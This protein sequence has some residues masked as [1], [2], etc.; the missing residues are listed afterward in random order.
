MLAVGCQF[1]TTTGVDVSP[2]VNV[3]L[4]DQVMPGPSG[5]CPT[6]QC[7]PQWYPPLPHPMSMQFNTGLGDISV[8][9]PT[10]WSAPYWPYPY[11]NA[12]TFESEFRL[13][14]RTGNISVCNRGRNKFDKKSKPPYG[15]CVQHEEWRSYVSPK[16]NMP[17]SRFG[18]AFYHTNPACI[19]SKWP[20]F[21]PP[22]P[23]LIGRL[24]RCTKQTPKVDHKSFLCSVFGVYV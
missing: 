17:E 5:T 16:T 10:Q 20:Y 1:C 2:S 4:Y 18:Y 8:Q 23:P 12:S 19:I 15:L 24:L 21:R 9:S 11:T 14:F 6:Y 22:P 13:C 3:L 7:G